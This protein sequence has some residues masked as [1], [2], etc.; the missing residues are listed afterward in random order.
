RH[1]EEVRELVDQTVARFGRIDAAVNNAGTEGQKGLVIDQTAESY[2]ATFDTNVLG[3]LLSLK[4]E[5]RVM[6]AQKSGNIIQQQTVSR[7]RLS[8]LPK[9]CGGFSIPMVTARLS[10]ISTNCA[11]LSIAWKPTRICSQTGSTGEHSTVNCGCWP[12]S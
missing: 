1:E 5:L 9:P 11:K 3:V 4:H 12:K 6:S 10:A 7:I 2:A 8:S